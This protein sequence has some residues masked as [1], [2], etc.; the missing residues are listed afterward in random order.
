MVL[1]G[2]VQEEDKKYMYIID[3]MYVSMYNM[4]IHTY[5]HTDWKEEI[6]RYLQMTDC[7]NRKSQIYKKFM[8]NYSKT[9]G[10]KVNIQNQLLLYISAMKTWDLK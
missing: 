6:K 2:L 7:V 4:Y 1:E 10:H 3:D 5:T 9:I 8:K